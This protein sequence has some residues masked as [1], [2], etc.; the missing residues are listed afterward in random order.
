MTFIE[1][2]RDSPIYH[3]YMSRIQECSKYVIYSDTE[4]KKWFDRDTG[5]FLRMDVRQSNGEFLT[6]ISV[7]DEEA[8]IKNK[9]NYLQ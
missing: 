7:Y 2:V 5:I 6:I 8:Y 4:V 3:L 1:K 9:K